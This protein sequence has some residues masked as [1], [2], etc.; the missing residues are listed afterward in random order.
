M[1]GEDWDLGEGKEKEKERVS[2]T[3]DRGGGEAR[4]EGKKRKDEKQLTSVSTFK[5]QRSNFPVPSTDPN[6]A[7][8]TGCHLTSYT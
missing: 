6:T 1:D 7:G 5:F 2:G 4:V 3:S 8:L